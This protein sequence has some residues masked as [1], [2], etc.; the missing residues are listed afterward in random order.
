MTIADLIAKL[1]RYPANA[2]VT[3][4]DPDKVWLL[5]IEVTLLPAEDSIREVNF[6]AITADS[7][8]DEIE[9]QANRPMGSRTSTQPL[10]LVSRTTILP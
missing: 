8:S 4:L 9:G 7:G 1:S 10:T 5:P 3:L 2:R 6:V